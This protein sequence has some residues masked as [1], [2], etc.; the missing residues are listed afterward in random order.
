MFFEDTNLIVGA[1]AQK[2]PLK[3]TLQYSHISVLY[4]DTSI[5]V[6]MV[7]MVTMH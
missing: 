5:A 2:Y 4:G 7:T 1:I 3:K 6:T